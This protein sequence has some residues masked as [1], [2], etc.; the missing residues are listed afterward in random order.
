ML[1][2]ILLSWF[3]KNVVVLIT[4]YDLSRLYCVGFIVAFFFLNQIITGIF[5]S[6]IYSNAFAFCWFSVLSMPD[7]EAGF[8]IRCS[9][10]SGTSFIYFTLYLHIFKVF[11]Q[12]ILH[13]SAFIVWFFGILI[14]FITVII[15]FLGYV[16]PLTQMSYWG[17]TVFSNILST[18]PIVGQ[19]ICFWIWGSEFI[20]DFTL[21]KV[22]S[23]HIFMPFL[24]IF[25]ILLHLF[26]LHC[27]LSSDGFFDRLSF[28][29]EKQIFFNFFFFRDLTILL[30]YFL[31]FLYFFLIYWF[32]VFHEE[33]FDIVNVMK[34]SEKVIPEWFFLTFFGFIKAIP[35]KFGGICVLVFFIINFYILIFFSLFFYS[36]SIWYNIFYYFIFIIYVYLMYIGILSTQ[37]TLLF[38]FIE[39]LQFFVLTIILLL[40][41]KLI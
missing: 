2:F 38:P 20:Q 16:L 25:L 30:L 31:F 41:I 36:Y 17:L 37:V 21:V 40:F 6:F 29:Y 7:F 39:E 34:T 33:S 9:H 14:Y 5:L 28:Y 12:I 11:F 15:A 27:Y 8:L 1:H 35:D 32:F 3:Y 24:L 13:N 10:I 23:I 4:S 22:H 19:N 18:V 26:F